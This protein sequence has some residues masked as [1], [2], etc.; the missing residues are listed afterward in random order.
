[1]EQPE[2]AF[3]SLTAGKPNNLLKIIRYPGR[4]GETDADRQGVGHH[5]DTG[6]LTAVLQDA[7]SGLQVQTEKGWID[8]EPR[9]GTF[10]V[11]IGELLELAT[12][13]YLKATVHRVVSPAAGTERISA[14]FFLGAS[15]DAVVRPLKLPPSL[16]AEAHGPDRD[17]NNP[18]FYEV[19]MNTL[20][21]RLR[22]HPDVAQRHYAD[23]VAAPTV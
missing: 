8:A 17:P 2:S 20:K 7:T 1:L 4:A 21:S 11:N 12:D 16:A 10:V 22:S 15:F 19:G 23:L 18:L 5:K 13:G 9:E 3:D 14:A 6:L